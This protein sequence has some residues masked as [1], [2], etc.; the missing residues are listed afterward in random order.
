MTVPLLLRHLAAIGSRR[1][2]LP[3]KRQAL[4]VLPHLRNGD[5]DASLAAGFGVGVATAYRYVVEADAVLAAFG[6]ELSDAV[7]AARGKAFVLLD[8]TLNAIERIPHQRGV[9]LRQTQAP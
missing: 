5:S 1:R 9:L 7:R 8:G 6:P 3:P 2:T 4:L